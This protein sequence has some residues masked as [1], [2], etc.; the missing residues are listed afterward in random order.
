MSCTVWQL[1]RGGIERV[2]RFEH[3]GDA[4]RVLRTTIQRG[5]AFDADGEVL[6]SRGLERGE[7]AALERHVGA[8][9]SAPAPAPTLPAPSPEAPLPVAFEPPVVDDAPMQSL[10]DGAPEIAQDL[11]TQC[12]AE[13]AETGA[14]AAELRRER[15]E[16]RALLTAAEA[17]IDE[18]EGQLLAEAMHPPTQ[19]L[20]ADLAEANRRAIA[21]EESARKAVEEL[22]RAVARAD[23]LEADLAR[24][25]NSPR[26]V[27]IIAPAH[28]IAALQEHLQRRA[29]R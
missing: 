2:G 12:C 3:P 4:K 5:A 7:L 29:R 6:D 20:A 26:V 27:R 23:Q 21:A 18:L 1:A 28:P 10:F 24:R 14:E 25:G 22:A 13:A 19:R 11:R 9:L 17:R 15:N 8:W 16:S